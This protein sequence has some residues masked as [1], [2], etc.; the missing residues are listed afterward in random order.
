MPKL[1]SP[2]SSRRSSP[3]L[4]SMEQNSPLRPYAKGALVAAACLLIPA[5][6]SFC[7]AV[8][9]SITTGQVMVISVGKTETARQL[10]HWP[11]GW[12]RFASP[13]VLLGAIAVWAL[14]KSSQLAWWLSACLAVLGSSMLV[15]SL[16]FVSWRGVA[17]FTSILA[18]ICSALYVGN[19]FGRMAAIGF[20]VLVA[21]I[22]L[23]AANAA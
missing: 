7:S 1:A 20:V 14:S 19:R 21:V 23:V 9:S 6:I 22:G 4:G 3:T 18:F 15:F 8:I 17:A 11:L 16:W 2:A 10:V 13:F 5:V 12:S